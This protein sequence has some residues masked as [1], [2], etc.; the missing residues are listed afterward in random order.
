MLVKSNPKKSF[1]IEFNNIIFFPKNNIM[2][3]VLLITNHFYPNNVIA[4]QRSAKFAKY[5]H[6]YGWNPYVLCTKWIP[7]NCSTFDP[8]MISDFKKANII[9]ALPYHQPPNGSILKLVLYKISLLGMPNV[10]WWKMIARMQKYSHPEKQPIE[11]YKG[12]ILS[13]PEI[14]RKYNIDA[15]WATSPPAAPM[16]VADF[17]KRKYNIPWIADFRD[18]SD[19]K[20]LMNDERLRSQFIKREIEV[21]KSS[22]A[23]VTVSNPLANVLEKRHDKSVQIIPNGFDHEDYQSEIKVNN[24]FFNIVYTGNLPYPHRDPTLLFQALENLIQDKKIESSTIYISFYGVEAKLI[25][26]LAEKF[27]YLKNSIHPFSYVSYSQSI[28]IQKGA[29]ILLHLSH[30]NEK[31]ILTGKLFEYFG[32]RRPILSV[33]GDN[34]GVDELIRITKA[35]AACHNIEETT[36]QVMQWYEEWKRTGSIE[37]HGEDKEIMKFTRKQQAK[38]LANLLDQITKL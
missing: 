36:K 38:Q 20:T 15:I 17:I 28:K 13:I 14:L 10:L 12:A 21:L 8:Q 31:G 2:K 1:K 7:Q 27:E 9:K 34:D 16:V 23:M 25:K 32:A 24:E 5:L 29:L 18:I 37:Y 3:N 33:P 6:Q 4:T 19:Q 22:S 35:G 11:F 30:K 26:S